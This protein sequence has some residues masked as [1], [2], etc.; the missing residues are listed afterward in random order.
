MMDRTDLF[1]TVC[2]ALAS[3]AMALIDLPGVK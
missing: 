2:C 3:L 1:V